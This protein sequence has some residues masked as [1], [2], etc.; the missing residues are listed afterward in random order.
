MFPLALFLA[1][2]P[3]PAPPCPLTVIRSQ[4]GPNYFVEP[5]VF[6]VHVHN[7]TDKVIIGSQF[8]IDF[9][10]AVGDLV[11]Y[12]IP[13]DAAG[14]IKPD[15]KATFSGQIYPFYLLHHMNGYRVSVH[16][17]QFADG[18][19]WVDDGTLQCQITVD[20]RHK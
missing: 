16:K 1:F 5:H 11:P 12:D 14:T 10:N 4:T 6:S 18:S 15:K 3:T 7:E 9:M 19:T 8:N 13:L 20:Y 17:L 2:Q